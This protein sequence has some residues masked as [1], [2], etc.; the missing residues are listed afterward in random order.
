MSSVPVRAGSSYA[1]L[2]AIA[3][4]ALAVAAILGPIH[5]TSAFDDTFITYTYAA[6]LARGEGLTW[7]GENVLG[8]S[9]PFL[10]LLLGGLEALV[11]LGVPVWG[12]VVSWLSIVV[13]ALALVALGR[14]EGWPGA[15][16]FAAA[17]LPLQLFVL[18]NL[19][20]EMLPALAA[21]VLAAWLLSAERWIEAG[22][23]LA[24]G[25]AFRGES[26]VAVAA[27]ALA[28]AYARRRS[29]RAIAPPL[30]RVAAGFLGTLAFWAVTLFA[31]TGALLPRTLAAKRAQ[32]L[33]DL[34]VWHG[35]WV[36]FSRA[37]ESLPE[38]LWALRGPVGV[39]LAAA[40]LSLGGLC[41]LRSRPL[42]TPGRLALAVWGPLQ[43]A[44]VAGLGVAFYPW[45]A[46]SFYFSAAL[47]VAQIWEWPRWH[48][49]P[50]ATRELTGALA[51]LAVALLVTPD[52]AWQLARWP[53]P[54]RA[55]YE[56]VGAN[57]AT[58]SPEIR[59]AAYEVGYLGHSSRRPV[60]DLLG[61][62]TKEASFE[63]VRS[64]DLRANL[65]LL[66]PGLVMLPLDGGSLFGRTIGDAASFV[67]RYRL[68]RLELDPGKRLALF[69]RASLAGSSEVL[70]DLL[71][72]LKSGGASV[73]ARG[74]ALSALTARLAP[75]SELALQLPENL[76]ASRF[77]SGY[78]SGEDAVTPATPAITA[79]LG[80]RALDEKGKLV[81]E[82]SRVLPIGAWELWSYELPPLASG[83]QLVLR[84]E[85]TAGAAC[86]L[87]FPHLARR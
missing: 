60:L 75:S 56:R 83:G 6:S 19:G 4:F 68:E 86:D 46:I 59:I 61:L 28:Y 84:C 29:N 31:L 53:D 66:A 14:R 37:V 79:R 77:V 80:L 1:P 20:S 8:T 70:L 32:A 27:L 48:Q 2:A 40:A 11:P 44:L 10:A 30:T 15:A 73:F 76:V 58:L 50:A 63:N 64:G 43:L 72:E 36:T 55:I 3:I 62:V 67:D 74:L 24:I 51:G 13:A 16:A 78:A 82:S 45:Y 22:I 52:P 34:G 18:A 42:S 26:I 85:S 35:G 21:V 25:T 33:S 7:N 65:D 49:L 17:A 12:A 71:P 5:G 81:A 9:T 69:R 23:A 54:R 47:V 41:L 87:A 38:A 57:L 39:T